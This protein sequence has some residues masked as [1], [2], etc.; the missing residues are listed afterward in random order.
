MDTDNAIIVFIKL[1]EKVYKFI[2]FLN[3][4]QLRNNKSLNSGLEFVFEL[5]LSNIFS[6]LCFFLFWEIFVTH[7]LEIRVLKDILSAGSFMIIF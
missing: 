3:W 6:E 2:L 4:Q 7:I 5:K 1:S